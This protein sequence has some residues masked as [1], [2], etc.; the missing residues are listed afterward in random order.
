VCACAL[1]G[2]GAPAPRPAEA[3]PAEDGAALTR[4]LLAARCGKCHRSDLPTAVPG[5]LA[6][7]D[8]TE[9]LWYTR[10][11]PEQTDRLLARLRGLA[12]L[13]PADLA[14]AET[15]LEK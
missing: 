15:F 11:S 3:A 5:A 10:L 2:G 4:D 14:A 1:R 8:L 13:D 9:E 6:V 7:F 12:D